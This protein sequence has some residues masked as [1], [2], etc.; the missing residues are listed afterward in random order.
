MV[1]RTPSEITGPPSMSVQPT[2]F[3][4]ARSN[5][6]DLSSLGLG[7]W[8]SRA[9]PL[10]FSL[11]PTSRF[12]LER[13]TGFEP[14]IF[15]LA[16]RRAT[17][18]PLPHVPPDLNA[19]SNSYLDIDRRRLVPPQEISAGRPQPTSRQYTNVTERRWR[20]Q[21]ACTRSGPRRAAST[22]LFPDPAPSGPSSEGQ[23]TATHRRLG[24]RRNLSCGNASAATGPH[25][26]THLTTGT[27]PTGTLAR[28]G[29]VPAGT[30]EA[31]HTT[32]LRPRR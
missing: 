23:A 15:S 17:T 1:W 28:M 18:A 31:N 5:Y 13:E 7:S 21:R 10:Q 11:Q 6:Q 26:A 12:G 29:R 8:Q 14:A 24:R 16:R 4:G 27:N 22:E 32:T 30:A 20:G 3:D 25:P 9:L 2:D 19:R